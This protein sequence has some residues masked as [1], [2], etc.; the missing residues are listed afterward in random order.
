MDFP[1]LWACSNSSLTNLIGREYE[2]NSLRRFRK[3]D[4]AGGHDSWCW[5]KGAW[6]LGTRMYIISPLRL[7][8]GLLCTNGCINA[9]CTLFHAFDW[10]LTTPINRGEQLYHSPT[11]WIWC[12]HQSRHWNSTFCS[13][14]TC[15]IWKP[16]LQTL[17]C[18][19]GI[20]VYW[21]NLATFCETVNNKWQVPR[22]LQTKLQARIV[23]WIWAVIYGEMP[24]TIFYF[25]DQSNN[26]KVQD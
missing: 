13:N 24:C 6:P 3:S 23:V 25:Y 17:L 8:F 7:L 26:C 5:P 2:T 19:T 21:S 4:L 10:I 1:S 9:N 16:I 11:I 15:L 22:L 14:K 12:S 20:H 18:A